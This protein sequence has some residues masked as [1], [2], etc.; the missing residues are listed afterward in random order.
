MKKDKIKNEKEYQELMKRIEKI[1][2]KST[3]NGGAEKLSTKELQNL[4]TL[5]LMAESYEDSIPL[6]PIKAPATLVEMIRY[7]M[8]EMNLKQ[9]QLAKLLQISEARISELLSGKRR[10][11]IDLA[12]KLHSKL[13]IDAHF[14]LEAA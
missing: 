9:K 13:K 1:L 11:T 14:I 7:K 3:K 10:I 2:Q 8:Y 5:S 4:K 12:K 6:M